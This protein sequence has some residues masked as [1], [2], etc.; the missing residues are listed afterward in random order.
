MP[1]L[2]FAYYVAN[3]S[4]N[5]GKDVALEFEREFSSNIGMSPSEYFNK[6]RWSHIP[7]KYGGK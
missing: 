4:G 3:R 5:K 6:I 7:A 2:A 1:G